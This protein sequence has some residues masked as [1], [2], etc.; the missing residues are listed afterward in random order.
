MAFAFGI[1]LLALITGWMFLGAVGIVL[2][3][4][5]GLHDFTAP[6]SMRRGEP[7]WIQIRTVYQSK[8]WFGFLVCAGIC[9]S[10]P[11][12]N[13]VL[14]PSLVAGGTLLRARRP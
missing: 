5:L 1:L 6:A 10:I 11:F 13:I 2:V 3:G 7:L 8:G 4:W 14:L 9:A 12:V